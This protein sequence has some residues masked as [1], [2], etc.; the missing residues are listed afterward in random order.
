[1]KQLDTAT[2]R[3]G[4]WDGEAKEFAKRIPHDNPT[5]HIHTLCRDVEAGGLE[6]LNVEING[7]RAG[8]CVY[9]IEEKAKKEMVIIAAF[10]VSGN[11]DL[12][13]KLLPVM[14]NFAK[15]SGCA[16]MRFHTCRGGLVEKS[17][18]QGFRVSEVVMRKTI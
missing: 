12:T 6:V 8:I 11:N 16:S 2:L 18:L 9:K 10:A 13:L 3:R 15:E 5:A 7:Q 4:D 14:E 17:F 1:M